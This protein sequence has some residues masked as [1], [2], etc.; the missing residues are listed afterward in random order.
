MTG[1]NIQTGKFS[2]ADDWEETRGTEKKIDDI[3]NLSLDQNKFTEHGERLVSIIQ[4]RKRGADG[5][6]GSPGPSEEGYIVGPDSRRTSYSKVRLDGREADPTLQNRSYD[7]DAEFKRDAVA[8]YKPLYDPASS[9]THAAKVNRRAKSHIHANARRSPQ[10]SRNMASAHP[11]SGISGP[12]HNKP[13]SDGQLETPDVK[14]SPGNQSR[15]YQDRSL[16]P[17]RA[18]PSR[19]NLSSP[20]Q[21]HLGDDSENLELEPELLLQP[22]TRPISLDQLVVEVK[23]IY[24]GLVMVEAKCIDIDERQ[25]VAAQEKDS[26]KRFDLKNDQWQSLI[27][28]HKQ[29]GEVIPE[30]H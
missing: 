30:P 5:E 11:G 15:E 18:P 3:G 9:T 13:Y 23:G 12:Y 29:V 14:P 22:E 16:S 6:P 24:A 25:S 4:T 8:S 19:I 21:G 26:S 7:D 2:A 17:V 20:E 1:S 27:A 28:L 10:T